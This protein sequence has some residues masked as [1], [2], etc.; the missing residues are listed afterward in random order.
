MR[1]TNLKI[2]IC[3]IL[4]AAISNAQSEEHRW[5][6]LIVNETQKTWIDILSL[7]AGTGKFFDVW[8]LEMY[9]PLLHLDGI[10][11]DIYRSKTKYAVNLETVKYGILEVVYYDPSNKEIYRFNYDSPVLTESI[12]YTYPVLENSILHLTIKEY[13]KLKEEGTN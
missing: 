8:I 3:I 9:T 6:P 7:E 13:L 2:F 12:K 1:F 10:S 11:G 5:K 4:L